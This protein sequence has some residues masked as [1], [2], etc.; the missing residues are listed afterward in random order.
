MLGTEMPSAKSTFTVSVALTSIMVIVGDN[1]CSLLVCSEPK[2]LGLIRRL[3]VQMKMMSLKS[4]VQAST[5]GLTASLKRLVRTL[6]KKTNVMFSDTLKKWTPL[7][8]TL[9]AETSETIMM[10]RSVER[11]MNKSP[12]YLTPIARN[13]VVKAG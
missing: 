12:S 8:L 13:L 2:K 3:R 4:L 7:S 5:R 10:V 6:V 9:T 11:L 1:R